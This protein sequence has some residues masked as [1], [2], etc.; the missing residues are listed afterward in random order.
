MEQPIIGHDTCAFAIAKLGSQFIGYD[1]HKPR[2]TAFAT[3]RTCQKM[4]YPGSPPDEEEE[5]RLKP[6]AI[7]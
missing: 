4:H 2:L 5:E 1:I 3:T 7:N 6:T